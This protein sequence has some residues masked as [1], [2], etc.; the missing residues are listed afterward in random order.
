M[1]SNIATVDHDFC[2]LPFPLVQSANDR[3]LVKHPPRRPDPHVIP[4]RLRSRTLKRDRTEVHNAQ[5]E[6]ANEQS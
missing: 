3:F 5:T 6:V 2:R 4:Q 1:P